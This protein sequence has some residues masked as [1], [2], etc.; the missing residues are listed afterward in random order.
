[1]HSSVIVLSIQILDLKSFVNSDIISMENSEAFVE[2]A[3]TWERRKIASI[4]DS[5]VLRKY[6]AKRRL[7]YLSGDPAGALFDGKR[8]ACCST[9]FGAGL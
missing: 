3:N 4:N 5:G 8:S 9:G 1:M 2:S 6:T 7:L